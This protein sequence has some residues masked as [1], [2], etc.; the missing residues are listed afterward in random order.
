M[1]QAAPPPGEP[2]P[3]GPAGQVVVPG[4]YGIEPP[5]PHCACEPVSSRVSSMRPAA[6]GQPP[7]TLRRLGAVWRSCI[8][9]LVLTFTYKSLIQVS[10]VHKEHKEHTDGRPPPPLPRA[11]AAW[12]MV[13][14]DGASVEDSIPR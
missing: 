7:A 10:L 6:T 5:G 4:G 8:K 3:G 13:W 1:S 14:V 9:S 2:P 12:F 11:R